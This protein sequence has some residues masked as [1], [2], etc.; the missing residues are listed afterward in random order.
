MGKKYETINYSSFGRSY[1]W[2]MMKLK[3]K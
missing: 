2:K 1:F 3:A